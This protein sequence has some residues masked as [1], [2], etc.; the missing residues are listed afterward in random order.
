MECISIKAISALASALMAISFTVYVIAYI[1]YMNRKWIRAMDT[2]SLF[3]IF[4]IVTKLFAT[5]VFTIKGYEL[6]KK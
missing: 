1:H 5:Y 3:N 6:L 4:I 2:N